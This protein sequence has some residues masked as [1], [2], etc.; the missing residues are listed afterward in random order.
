MSSSSSL[1]LGGRIYFERFI[2]DKQSGSKTDSRDGIYFIPAA[3]DDEQPMIVGQS[4][5]YETTAFSGF[6][7]EKIEFE[8]FTLNTGIRLEAFEQ[9]RV[10][11]LSGSMYQDKSPLNFYPELV[12]QQNFPV[13]IFLL[14]YIE[15]LHPLQVE[16]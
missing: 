9:E 11:R 4:H 8:K 16:H 13:L 6:L 5:H 1:E 2:D 10:D 15:V 3:S 12:L 7:N 14:V